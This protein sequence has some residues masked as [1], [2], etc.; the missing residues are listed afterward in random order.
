MVTKTITAISSICYLISDILHNYVFFCVM[1]Y[2]LLLH[3]RPRGDVTALA[4][5]KCIGYLTNTLIRIVYAYFIIFCFIFKNYFLYILEKTLCLFYPFS[6]VHLGTWLLQRSHPLLMLPSKI[7][8][9]GMLQF[10]LYINT[11]E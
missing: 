7:T 11:P 10:V 3:V 1:L 4:T 9:Q 2:G 6:R 5:W 8:T